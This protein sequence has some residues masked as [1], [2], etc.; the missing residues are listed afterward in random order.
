MDYHCTNDSFV[1]IDNE[2]EATLVSLSQAMR[3][4][5]MCLQMVQHLRRCGWFTDEFL[6]A[7]LHH[8]RAGL[9]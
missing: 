6:E 7:E 4:A 9:K 1:I 3:R 2:P 5:Y 8:N